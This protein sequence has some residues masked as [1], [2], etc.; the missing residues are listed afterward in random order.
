MTSATPPPL[1]LM[2]LGHLA[3]TS[4]SLPISD[5]TLGLSQVA[6]AGDFT[7][8]TEGPLT[9]CGTHQGAEPGAQQH[10]L[11]PSFYLGTPS[12]VR[13]PSTG[14]LLASADLFDHGPSAACWP[15][16][17]VA[18]RGSSWPKWQRNATL[19]RRSYLILSYL[20]LSYLILSYLILSYVILSYVILTRPF[21]VP[22]RRQW[23]DLDVS[24]L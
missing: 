13:S 14:H 8:A 7:H 24:R 23:N 1:L 19:Y 17:F 21:T 15:H 4:C 2:L 5:S 10:C 22:Q 3:A 6:W 12:V 20:I 11:D 9:G 18:H 16:F